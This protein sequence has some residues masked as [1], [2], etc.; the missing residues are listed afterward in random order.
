MDKIKKKP[1]RKKIF[2]VYQCVD[3]R[4]DSIQ[5]P[6]NRGRVFP[7]RYIGKTYNFTK[8]KSKHYSEMRKKCITPF[9]KYLRAVRKNYHRWSI[10]ADG[11]TEKQAM[12]KEKSLIKFYDTNVSRGGKGGYNATDGGDGTSGYKYTEEQRKAR[13]GE[14]NPNWQKPLTKEQKEKISKTKTGVKQTPE[15]IEII[16]RGHQKKAL[17]DLKKNPMQ[18]IF[19]RGNRY[20]VMIQHK[21]QGLFKT[22]PEAM[23]CRDKYY[24]VHF[25]TV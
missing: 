18:C 12:D 5:K 22:V 17:D 10:I 23:A 1:S 9:H 2:C 13:S 14:N 19:K 3:S 8:R 16:T 4:P 6:E 24:H 20:Q 15:Q 21:Y 7:K 25:K 11:L